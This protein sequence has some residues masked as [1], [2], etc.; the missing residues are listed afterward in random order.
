MLSIENVPNWQKYLIYSWQEQNLLIGCTLFPMKYENIEFMA[1]L[2]PLFFM[3]NYL[4]TFTIMCTN[5]E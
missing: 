1:E 3:I 4:Y 5:F 2:T